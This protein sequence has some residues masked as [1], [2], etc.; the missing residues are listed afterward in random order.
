MEA[1]TLNCPMCGAACASAAVACGHCGARL[2]TVACPS[3]FGM[4]FIGSN[5]CP[6][7]GTRIDRTE[8]KSAAPRLCP[9]C[10]EPLAAITLGST[11][12]LECPRCSGLWI[13]TE[14]FNEI[15]A[16]REKQAAVIGGTSESL[17]P[18]LALESVHYVPCPVCT[19]LMN[20]VNFARSS[21]VILDICKADGVWFDREE[22]RRVV[23]FVHGGG[24]EMSRE[25]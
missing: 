20:R 7:C 25:R 10:R 24:L 4:I 13:D 21:G 3:C 14:T 12:A 5:F 2:A 1:A 11:K 9:R 6:H 16:D 18:D 8:E 19:K 23:E 17:E 15:C 22:L